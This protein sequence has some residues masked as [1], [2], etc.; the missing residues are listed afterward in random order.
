VPTRQKWF[1]GQF[2]VVIRA[3][4]RED[5]HMAGNETAEEMLSVAAV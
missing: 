4:P 5:R 2:G 3:T 1:T